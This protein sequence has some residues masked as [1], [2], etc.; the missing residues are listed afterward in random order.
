MLAAEWEYCR[1]RGADVER[2]I[3]HPAYH[4]IIAMAEPAVSWLL[5]RLA[6]RPYHWFAALSAITG[7]QART[8]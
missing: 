1:P 2:M 7:R 6:E 3:E 8:P 4:A 5:R